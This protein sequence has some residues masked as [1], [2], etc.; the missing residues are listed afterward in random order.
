MKLE[1]TEIHSELWMKLKEHME[2]RLASLRLQNDVS[3]PSDQ[4]EK[5]RGRIAELKIL[6]ALDQ[7]P[8]IVVADD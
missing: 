1:E 4:T 6:L 2:Q 8:A 3:K 5:L 7:A